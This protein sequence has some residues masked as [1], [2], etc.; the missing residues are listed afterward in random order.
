MSTTPRIVYAKMAAS[1]DRNRKI[2]RGGRECREIYLWVLR[3]CADRDAPGV[4][5]A[6]DLL[7][8]EFM[9]D[10]LMCSSEDVQ[11]G[12]RA[13][14]RV[15][16]LEIVGGEVFVCGWEDEW[17]DNAPLS[18]AERQ[19][20]YRERSCSGQSGTQ[21]YIVE[22]GGR[23]KIGKSL[24]P[25][26]RV[27]SLQTGCPDEIRVLLVLDGDRESELHEALAEFHLRG[28]W[29]NGTPE[30]HARLAS[31]AGSAEVL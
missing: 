6:A 27:S 29:F 2:R 5:P 20:R 21:T 23:V 12:T 18:G 22:A 8:L 26:H 14:I 4:I 3:C 10:T 13:A 28:E 30:F 9:A 19:R 25:V 31:L 24:N 7:D 1:L 16:L 15:G 17:A 11:K